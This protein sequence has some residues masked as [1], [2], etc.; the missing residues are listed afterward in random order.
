MQEEMEMKSGSAVRSGPVG[1]GNG[2]YETSTVRQKQ[3]LEV[4]VQRSIDL[5]V[6]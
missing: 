4:N 5:R 1:S 3:Q 6:L 2:G